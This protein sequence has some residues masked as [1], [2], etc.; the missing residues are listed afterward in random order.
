MLRVINGVTGDANVTG[1]MLWI[2][3]QVTEVL[4]V[5]APYDPKHMSPYDLARLAS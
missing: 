1:K 5:F 4:A 3:L 2:Q